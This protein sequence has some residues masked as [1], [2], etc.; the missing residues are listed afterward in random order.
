MLTARN[1]VLSTAVF[2]FTISVL[3]TASGCIVTEKIIFEDAVNHAISIERHNPASSV[4]GA[5]RDATVS[6]SALV[7]DED[8][9]DLE[10]NLIEGLLELSTNYWTNK[11]RGTTDYC[12]LPELVEPIDQDDTSRDTV[13]TFRIECTVNLSTLELIEDSGSILEVRLIVSDLGFIRNQPRPGSNTAEI[14]WVVQ[15]LQDIQ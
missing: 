8:V 1:R 14:L 10:Q 12:K 7:R 13:P 4:Y 6:F 3:L 5:E 15:M 11:I 9:S 2:L